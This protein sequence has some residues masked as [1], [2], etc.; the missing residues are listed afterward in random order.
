VQT[1]EQI[2]TRQLTV[3]SQNTLSWAHSRCS[4][5]LQHEEVPFRDALGGILT[6]LRE[7]L[8]PSPNSGFDCC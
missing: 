3:P 7:L 5:S 1:I 4:H 6:F 2:V 8:T